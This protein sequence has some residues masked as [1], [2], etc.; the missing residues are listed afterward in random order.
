M[1]ENNEISQ[2]TEGQP[3]FTNEVP[4][5]GKISPNQQGQEGHTNVMPKSGEIHQKEEKKTIHSI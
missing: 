5:L 2:V 1:V 4:R 3:K